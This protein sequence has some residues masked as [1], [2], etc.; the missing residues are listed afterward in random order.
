MEEYILKDECYKIIGACMEVHNELGSGFL[1]AVYSEALAREFIDRGIPF[2][3]DISL[4]VFYKREKLNK[5]Y[6]ADFVCF[7]QIILE[8]KAMEGLT[9]EH[10]AQVLNYLKATGFR[11]GLLI[12]FGSSKLQYKRVIL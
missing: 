11:I 5:F 10:L 8:L 1:E 4:D 7:D 3:S 12:N 6:V 9:D 2:H